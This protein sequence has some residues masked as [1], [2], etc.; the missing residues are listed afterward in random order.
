MASVLLKPKL[1]SIMKM[2]PLVSNRPGRALRNV[3][4]FSLNSSTSMTKATKLLSITLTIL[5]ASI[6]GSQQLE[7]QILEWAISYNGI[8]AS[9]LEEVEGVV[10]DAAGNV[11]ATG[12]SGNGTGSAI[13][14]M[15]LGP[16][17]TILWIRVESKSS[18]CGGMW[19]RTP[20]ARDAA[21][22]LVVVGAEFTSDSSSWNPLL[23]IYRPD[24]ST[25]LRRVYYDLGPYASFDAVAVDAS[26]IYVVAHNNPNN[27]NPHVVQT[28]KLGATAGEV[29][30][31]AS[32]T[33]GT[34]WGT[35][36]GIVATG[37]GV[38]TAA[39]DKVTM[40]YLAT[41]DVVWEKDMIM[42]N[43][44]SPLA[45]DGTG[46][47]YVVPF[48]NGVTKYD[49]AGKAIQVFNAN[50]SLA[51]DLDVDTAGNI[52]IV[53][54]TVSSKSGSDILT[55]KYSGLTG[56]LVWSTTYGKSGQYSDTGNAITVCGGYVYVGASKYNKNL[57]MCT[58]KYRAGN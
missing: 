28:L 9:A 42:S 25:F 19:G 24:G 8:P 38:Y 36:G 3:A 32:F 56:N 44:G 39:G 10:A 41:G 55:Q 47:I 23:L 34:F 11:Y 6:L 33:P 15:M 52:Y 12:L 5:A 45:A 2:K 27:G 57:D 14:T 50:S 16:S 29:V 54:S 1:V 26:G 21:G 22:N 20:L 51:S 49:S 43:G 58:L 48:Q 31:K 13:C 35:R 46:N 7:A 17:G 37:Y 18:L 4:G 30:W 40:R 53:G